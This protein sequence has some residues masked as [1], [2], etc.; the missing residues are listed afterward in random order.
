MIGCTGS[1]VI[2]C[3]RFSNDYLKTNTEAI[4]P[5]NY[6]RSK[7]RDE[8]ITIPSSYLK[9]AQSAGGGG[10]QASADCP[11]FTNLCRNDA[12]VVGEHLLTPAHFAIVILSPYCEE[13]AQQFCAL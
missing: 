12:R 3:Q 6:N 13:C 10:A 4:T 2:C 7:Q 1:K 5:P 9:L 8:P 11:K